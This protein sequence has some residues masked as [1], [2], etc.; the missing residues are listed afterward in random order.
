MFAVCFKYPNLSIFLMLLFL[1]SCF[2]LYFNTQTQTL[3]FGSEF[4]QR[5]YRKFNLTL[6][7]WATA[8]LFF[9]GTIWVYV[10]KY[11]NI[12]RL[13]R[14]SPRFKKWYSKFNPTLFHW[15]TG[16]FFSK[17][18]DF[19]KKNSPGFLKVPFSH[20]KTCS[21]K[22]WTRLPSV[23]WSVRLSTMSVRPS[24]FPILFSTVTVFRACFLL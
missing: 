20:R 9:K 14:I 1:F 23:A 17:K 10:D 19:W 24:E 11:L 13:V 22:Y 8:F 4:F 5:C 6:L 7:H 3:P 2:L 18:A 15:N 21:F 12:A 16:F